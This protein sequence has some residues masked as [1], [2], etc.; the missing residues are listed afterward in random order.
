MDTI[1]EET[2]LPADIDAQPL[3]HAAAAERIKRAAERV[4]AE[5]LLHQH[6]QAHHALAHVRDTAGDVDPNPGWQ[7]DQRSASAPR[8]RRSARPST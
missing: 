6:R 8:T 2:R 7:R 3:V 5:A 1:T 4:L